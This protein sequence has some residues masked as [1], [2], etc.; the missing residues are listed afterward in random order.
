MNSGAK[1][2]V[3]FKTIEGAYKFVLESDFRITKYTRN[4]ERNIGKGVFTYDVRYF[5]V[6]FDLPTNPNQISSDVA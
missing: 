3:L 4:D 6:I 1:T 5:W 2:G